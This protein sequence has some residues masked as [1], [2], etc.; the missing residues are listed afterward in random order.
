MKYLFGPVN[1]RRLGLSQ[2][3]DLLTT[4]TCTLDC[5]YCEVGR[6]VIHSCERR[7][8]TP[9]ADIIAEINELLANENE[10]KPIDVCTITA[11][12][13]PTLH[14]G[15][16]RI[17]R[18]IKAKIGKPVAI[19]TN[20]TLMH[21]PD[22]QEELM[23][24]D[25]VIP[26]LDAARAESFRRINRPAHCVDLDR[27][28]SG[29][30]QFCQNFS[31]QVWLEVLLCKEINDSAQDIDALAQAVQRIKPD[32]VQLNTVVRP[33][34]ETFAEA[35][36]EQELQRIA[37]QLTGNVEI[38]ASFAKRERSHLRTPEQTEILEMLQRR[39]CPSADI[40]EALNYDINDIK[41]FMVDLHQQG[42]VISHSHQGKTYYQLPIPPDTEGAA[43]VKD[44]P[45]S[46]P[47]K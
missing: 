29:T 21:R 11:T 10:A 25:I 9:T 34:L 1:S 43:Q 6:T 4:K 23:A 39:P 42:L 22:V 8:Y 14:S 3:I 20:G 12:G 46:S 19:L 17:I 2:G 18:H 16:G 5:I 26:S 33:P 44:C 15:L 13:E 24:A 38:I 7:E 31:G 47:K 45:C 27:I 36:S 30:E 28:I 32:R 37:S 41:P 35:L 40:A